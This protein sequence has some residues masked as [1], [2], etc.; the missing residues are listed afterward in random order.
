M[1][2]RREVELSMKG[3]RFINQELLGYLPGRTL[4]AIKGVRKRPDYR[5][6]VREHVV[7]IQ[8]EA[9]VPTVVDS[10]IPVVDEEYDQPLLEYFQAFSL[11]EICR[12]VGR[13]DRAAT[14]ERLTALLLPHLQDARPQRIPNVEWP[15][16]PTC[17]V[18]SNAVLTTAE[19]KNSGVGILNVVMMS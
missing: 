13:E 8:A 6:R 11:H 14:L 7:R 12:H 3:V 5:T 17:L 18:A 2:A 10:Q 1:L 4:E 19:C 16:R 9:M 15:G